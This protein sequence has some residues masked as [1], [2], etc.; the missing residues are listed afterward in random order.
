MKIYSGCIDKWLC[1]FDNRSATYEQK[2]LE[3]VTDLDCEDL[4]FIFDFTEALKD[5]TVQ[6]NDGWYLRCNK[7][8]FEELVEQY[9]KKYENFKES[10]LYRLIQSVLADWDKEKMYV[11]NYKNSKMLTQ[12]IGILY[13]CSSR[14]EERK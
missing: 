12:Y 3:M 4:E 6:N 5:Y 13:S 14:I 1:A 8:D 2:T 7:N 10:Q 11:D 9:V